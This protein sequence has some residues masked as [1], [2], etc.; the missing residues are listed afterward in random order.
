MSKSNNN[1]QGQGNTSSQEQ[2]S[3]QL[4]AVIIQVREDGN[5]LVRGSREVD[6]NGEKR[7]TEITGVIRPSDINEN[8]SILSSQI[9]ELQIFHK[10]KGVVEQGQRPGIV[11]RLINWIF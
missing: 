10:G 5:L 8:N 11:M 6:V 9:A 3:S 1:Y 4:S 7:I 2:L